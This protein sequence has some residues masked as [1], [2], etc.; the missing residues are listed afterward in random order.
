[1][2]LTDEQ[3]EE[4]L[5]TLN[6]MYLNCLAQKAELKNI[7]DIWDNILE[8]VFENTERHILNFID[9]IQHDKDFE[10]SKNFWYTALMF[11]MVNLQDK[12]EIKHITSKVGFNGFGSGNTHNNNLS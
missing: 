10:F 7:S 1:M 5:L 2:K 6:D 8:E 9:K 4:I 3:R 11:E 12:E